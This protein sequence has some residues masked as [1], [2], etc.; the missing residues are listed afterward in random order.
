MAAWKT[1]DYLRERASRG[2]REKF[3]AAMDKVSDVAPEE[4]DR[5]P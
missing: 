3:K 1:V 4:A 5:I 2:N